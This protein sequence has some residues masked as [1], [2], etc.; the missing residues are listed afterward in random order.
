MAS[1]PTTSICT[2]GRS[3]RPCLR[4]LGCHVAAAQAH[5]APSTLAHRLGAFRVCNGDFRGRFS[6][7]N[8]D[9]RA[10]VGAALQPTPWNF[11]FVSLLLVFLLVGASDRKNLVVRPVLRFGEISYGLYLFHVLCFDVYDA[12][13]RRFCPTLVGA[14]R[15][16]EYVHTI[17]AQPSFSRLCLRFVVAATAGILVSYASRRWFETPFLR[18]KDRLAKPQSAFS[19]GSQ[20]GTRSCRLRP[21]GAFD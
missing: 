2:R 1:G 11:A 13:I 8:L 17:A 20:R 4:R 10:P 19:R 9:Q 18:L 15:G 14:V 6:S 21:G 12:L 16:D 5:R 3:G 7:R